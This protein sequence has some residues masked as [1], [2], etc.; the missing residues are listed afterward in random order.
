MSETVDQKTRT[1]EDHNKQRWRE[2]SQL[3][4]GGGLK[5]E[6]LMSEC[7]MMDIGW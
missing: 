7:R 6:S 4:D 1:G 3:E 5:K 2:E